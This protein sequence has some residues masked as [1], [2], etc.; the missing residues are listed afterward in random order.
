MKLIK[1]DLRGLNALQML[2]RARVVRNQMK[3]NPLFPA[4]TPSMADFEAAMDDLYASVRST[5]DGASRLEFHLKEK[6]REKVATMIKSLAAYVSIIAQGDTSIVLA[7]GFEQRRSSSKINTIAQPDH[8][9][10]KSGHMPQTIEVGWDPVRGARVYKV[11]I[12]KGFANDEG[13][14]TV[15]LT[16]KSRCL[17]ENLEPLEYYTMRIQAMGAHA[18]SPLSVMTSALSLGFKAA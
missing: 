5:Y 1:T 18:E 2:T 9:V 7:A 16:S 11:H 6:N 10:A 15:V 12:T 3:N 4:P 14:V 8:P 13:P 17:I